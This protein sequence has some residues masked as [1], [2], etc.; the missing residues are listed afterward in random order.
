VVVINHGRLVAT[1]A[2]ASL[3]HGRTSVCTHEAARLSGLLTAAGADVTPG[4]TA[5][6]GG[7]G[8]LLVR[9]I[10][11]REIGDRASAAGI[12]LHELIPQAD[13]LEELFLTWTSNDTNPMNGPG[14]IDVAATEQEA[15]TLLPGYD[16]SAERSAN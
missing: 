3:Q 13:S 14:I 2:L 8:D 15:A 4:G 10:G 16:W 1:G 6:A 12:A 11:I 9:G 5:H 7:D